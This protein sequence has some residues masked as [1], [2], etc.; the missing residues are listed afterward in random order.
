MENNIVLKGRVEN[1]ERVY[2]DYDYFFMT[3][4]Y[5]GLPNA[6]IES[7]AS[8]LICISTDC[9][10]GPRDLISQGKTGFLISVGDKNNFVD[11]VN[12]VFTINQ[13]ELKKISMNARKDILN[14]C[15]SQNTFSKL[16]SLIDEI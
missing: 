2:A 13:N 11:T 4:N 16:C 12:K 3:S 15:S 6:L 10:T 14:K 1:M 8:G 5:E 9:K 7:M